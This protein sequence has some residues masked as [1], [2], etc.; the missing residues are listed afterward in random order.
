MLQ[1]FKGEKSQKKVLYSSP[2]PA[3][4]PPDVVLNSVNAFS[5]LVIA[6]DQRQVRGKYNW[7]IDVSRK[8]ARILGVYSETTNFT[9]NKISE[10]IF[11]QKVN[12]PP[13]Y[14]RLRPQNGYWIKGL[15][16]KSEYNAFQDSFISDPKVLT[17]SVAAL[18]HRVGV[19]LDYEAGTV[20]FFNVT[21]RWVT[22]GSVSKRRLRSQDR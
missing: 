4:F 2:D 19:F 21:C 5:S 1:V 16:N 14:S 8:I 9:V 17:L 11:G 12:H 22:H 13:I 10:F 18:P 7:E 20:S 6:A 15:Q 3:I